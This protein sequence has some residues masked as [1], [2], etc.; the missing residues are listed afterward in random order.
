[1]VNAKLMGLGGQTERFRDSVCH[2]EKWSSGWV[3]AGR[4]LAGGGN[5]PPAR[6]P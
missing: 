4:E 2:R 1:M 3:Q 6:L 5:L